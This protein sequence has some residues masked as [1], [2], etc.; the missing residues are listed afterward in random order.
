MS[1]LGSLVLLFPDTFELFGLPIFRFW[2][3]L[4]GAAH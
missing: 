1:Y 3:Y 2:A 4:V